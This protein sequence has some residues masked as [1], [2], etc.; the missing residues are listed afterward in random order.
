MSVTRLN[1]EVRSHYSAE[2]I[3]RVYITNY[4]EGTFF[5]IR[6]EV[7]LIDDHTLIGHF[8][9]YCRRWRSQTFGD[10]FLS[11]VICSLAVRGLSAMV[12][13]NTSRKC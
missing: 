4:Y 6:G 3:L 10:F 1:S 8:W 2:S 11:K 5:S 7:V 9:E 13:F 12:F